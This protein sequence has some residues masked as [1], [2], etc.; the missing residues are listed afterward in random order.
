M[1]LRRERVDVEVI[2]AVGTL[3][4]VN[5]QITVT[6]QGK[7]LDWVLTRAELEQIGRAAGMH[8]EQ[9]TSH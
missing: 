6:R 3:T 4:H 7:I 5:F 8:A 2:P 9:E 1:T